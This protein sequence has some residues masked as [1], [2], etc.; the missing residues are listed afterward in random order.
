[1]LLGDLAQAGE[2]TD[3]HHHVHRQHLF[4]FGISHIVGGIDDPLA[5]ETEFQRVDHLA[6]ADGVESGP[7]VAQQRQ[8]SG[9]V[10]GFQRV[11]D[12]QPVI[13][14]EFEQIPV[15]LHHQVAVVHIQRRAVFLRKFQQGFVAYHT[16]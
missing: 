10:V 12:L 9:I 14:D 8:Q 1:M 6:G 3:V 2:R 13:R 4:K 15:A 11:M 16:Q 7:G 5:R